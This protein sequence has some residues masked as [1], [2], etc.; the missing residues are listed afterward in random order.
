MI[1]YFSSIDHRMQ[2]G[3]CQCGTGRTYLVKYMMYVPVPQKLIFFRN[4]PLKKGFVCQCGSG[5]IYFHWSNLFSLATSIFISR[6]YL[7]KFMVYVPVPQK[8]IFFPKNPSEK[9]LCLSMWE[10]PNLFSLVKSIFI[11][12]IYFHWSNLFCGIYGVRPS[13]T[14]MIFFW[15]IPLW[16]KALFV[17]VGWPNLFSLIKSIFIGQKNFVC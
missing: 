9:R 11:G 13:A 12:Q 5:R 2:P 7:V 3:D 8:L 16:K 4:I 14:K 6:T 15:K 17:N 10:W 1:N